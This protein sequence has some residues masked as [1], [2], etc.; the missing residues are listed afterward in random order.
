[1]PDMKIIKN[2]I[3]DFGK[4][5]VDY[6]FASIIHPFFTDPEKEHR[7]LQIVTNDDFIDR[8]DLENVPFT[9]IIEDMKVTYPEF[10]DAFDYF[11]DHYSDFVIGE[12]EGMYALL[13]KFK[14]MGFKLYGLTNWCGRVYEVIARYD[15][16]NLLDGYIIS[17]DVKMIKPD[18]AIYQ[19]LCDSFRLRPEEC[20]FT[21]DKQRNIDGAIAA[22]MKAILFTSAAAYERSLREFLTEWGYAELEKCL[23]GE[24]YD[25]HAPVFIERKSRAAEWVERYNSIP[26]SRRIER[27]E[28]LGTLF[29]R[30]GKNCSV[31]TD[32]ICDFGCNISLGNNVSINHRC[33]FVDSNKII[34]GDNVLIAP[35][36]QINTSSHPV[37]MYKRLNLDSSECGTAYFATTYSLPVKIGNGCWIGAGAIILG[38][39]TIGEGAVV[40]AGTV[41]TKDVEPYS[42]VGGV[43]GRLIR[44]L[45]VPKGMDQK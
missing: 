14:S 32:F 30:V 37:E 29:E 17:S 34:I 5:L 33:L 20:L 16:F 42:V 22:G 11:R 43:P 10:I 35:G 18:I 3:F 7:F 40:A 38:G 23:D 39:V 41:V 8:C 44:K 27:K 25:C 36:V 12:V 1:M 24:L 13:K 19:T 31:G 6:D 21:D 26:Y 9:E 45:A 15:I 2:L 4:V 28:M